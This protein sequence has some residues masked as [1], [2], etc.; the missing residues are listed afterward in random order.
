MTP[1]HERNWVI[2]APE[3]DIDITRAEE[4]SAMVDLR[5]NGHCPNT[6]IDLTNVSFMDSSGLGWLTRT[7]E[8]LRSE[9]GQLRIVLGD[10]SPVNR[11]L[12][13]TGLLPVF[14]VH[15]SVDAACQEG[16]T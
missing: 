15:E 6:V 1:T 14:C 2:F 8:H 4:L 11:L 7:Q 13:L 9:Y 10:E 16:T 12:N 3:G 5:C